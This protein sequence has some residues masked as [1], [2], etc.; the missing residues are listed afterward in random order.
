MKMERNHKKHKRH[1][2]L[3]PFVLLVVPFFLPVLPGGSRGA[4]GPA[5][6]LIGGRPENVRRSGAHDQF[7]QGA[8]G[9][10][11]IAEFVGR[12]AFGAGALS[13]LEC[14]ASLSHRP[15]KANSA[16]GVECRI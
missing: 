4:L 8:Y 9:Y 16:D 2:I 15:V 3:V 5:D 12:Q 6:G 14:G 7:L 10:L 1:K 13:D 11:S